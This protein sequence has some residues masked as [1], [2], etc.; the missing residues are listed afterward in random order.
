M[1]NNYRVLLN[2]SSL[3]HTPALEYSKRTDPDGFNIN[4]SSTPF[5]RFSNIL[6]AS[7]SYDSIL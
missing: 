5:A 2:S 3:V 4:F 7:P 1:K 6:N